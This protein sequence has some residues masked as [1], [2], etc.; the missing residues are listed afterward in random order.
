MRKSAVAWGSLVGKLCSVAGQTVRLYP[1]HSLLLYLPVD[2]RVGLYPPGLVFF[3]HTYGLFISAKLLV[4]P[5]FHT[6]NNK[7]QDYTSFI[8]NCR[9]FA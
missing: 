9:R 4:I 6:T 8:I 7:R 1:R 3:H 5:I 2:K